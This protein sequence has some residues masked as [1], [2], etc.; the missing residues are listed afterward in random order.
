MV[1]P[2]LPGTLAIYRTKGCCKLG[3]AWSRICVGGLFARLMTSARELAWTTGGMV[4]SIQV[5]LV[6][7]HWVILGRSNADCHGGAIGLLSY[8]K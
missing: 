6:A 7:A 8:G 1:V 4:V 2:L 3:N 5:D